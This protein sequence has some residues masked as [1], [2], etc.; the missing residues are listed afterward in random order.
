M[1]SVKLVV[2]M[3]A[4]IYICAIEDQRVNFI[5]SNWWLMILQ[6]G[7]ESSNRPVFWNSQILW[8]LETF[9]VAF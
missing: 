9:T 2:T 7:E 4:Y 6:S 5:D 3:E 8:G 1:I